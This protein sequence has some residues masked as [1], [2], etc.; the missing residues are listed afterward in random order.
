MDVHKI[1]WVP[2]LKLGKIQFKKPKESDTE[3]AKARGERVKKRKELNQ[4]GLLIEEI[5][6]T[7]AIASTASSSCLDTNLNEPSSGT[8]CDGGEETDYRPLRQTS[9]LLRMALR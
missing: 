3:A 1:D 2:T 9:Q 5:D 8:S 7:S 6:F 4:S